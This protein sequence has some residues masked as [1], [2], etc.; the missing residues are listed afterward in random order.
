MRN[1]VAIGDSHASLYSNIPER[2]RGVWSDPSLGNIFEPKW[3]GPFTFWRLCREQKSFIDFNKSKEYVVCDVKFNTKAEPN[4]EILIIF[5]EIDVRCHILK[6]GYS[7]YE[8]TVDNMIRLI[9]NYIESYNGK[10]KF[11]IQSIVPPIY[12]VNFGNKVPLFPFVGSDEERRDVTLYFNKKLKELCHKIN[13]GYF[14][15]FD[16]YSDDNNMMVLEKSDAIVHAI[17]TPEL[18]KRIKKYFKL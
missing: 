14:D 17:K 18:E 8:E 12:K 4:Q 9:E 16:I 10:F 3:L 6:F 7:K 15:I 11:H 13:I 2:N 1:I 5:G